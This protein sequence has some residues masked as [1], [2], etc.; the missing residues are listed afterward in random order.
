MTPD[1][2]RERVVVALRGHRVHL[3][4]Y[5]CEAADI[6]IRI[7]GEACAEVCR[8][9]VNPKYPAAYKAAAANCACA[10]RAL[11]RAEGEK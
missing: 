1:E 9:E 10:I 8:A 3:P 7:V 4:G 5:A 2:L 6:A 11:T